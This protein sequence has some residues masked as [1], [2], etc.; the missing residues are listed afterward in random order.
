MKKVI[1]FAL[2]LAI[3]L[4]GICFAHAA[5]TDSQDELLVYPTSEL[6]DPSVLEGLT[7]SMTLACGN[8]LR[9]H[10]DY[11]FGGDTAADFSYHLKAIPDAQEYDSSSLEV[12]L[13]GGL[14]SSTSGSFSL[15]SGGYGDLLRT[16]AAATA[17]GES[18]TMNLPLGEYVEYYVPDYSLSYEDD[19][20]VCNESASLHG[21]IT[22][23]RWYENEGIYYLLQSQFRFPVQETDII[24]VTL[25]KNS[26]GSIC[27]IGLDP[28][29]GPELFFAGDATAEGIWFVPIFRDESG[30][31]LAY[32]SP[33]GHGIYFAPWRNREE[34]SRTTEN[35]SFVTPD[36]TRLKLVYPLEEDLLINTI[37]IA[38]GEARLLVRTDDTYDLTIIDLTARETTLE[39][40]VLPHDPGHTSS[41]GSFFEKNGYLL[42]MAQ[43]KLALVDLSA[44][45]VVLTT[46]DP[47]H[48]ADW[49]NADTG[50]LR[51]DGQTLFLID[52][53]YSY[54]DGA[55]W[56]V[57]YRQGGLAYYGEYDCSLLRGNDDFYYRVI[58]VDQDPVRWK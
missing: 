24:S 36:L 34:S 40:E 2:V 42:V 14:G 47:D 51:F 54:R 55:F 56:T 7:A 44:G 31:P 33:Q 46:E 23:E 30:V 41:T 50:D 58:T 26:A 19:T 17:N 6:G 4:G 12:Y 16:V 21:Q 38:D 27:A 18:L 45:Q 39:L 29:N 20:R 11:T 25:E 53:M 1:V 43:Q 28:L 35:Q 57:A 37:R 10:T 13:S 9:W 3:A 49:F 5:T 22:S 15:R 32:E 52:A 48:Y 8:H